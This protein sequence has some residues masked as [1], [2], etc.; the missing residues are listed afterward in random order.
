MDFKT[1][2]EKVSL[3]YEKKLPFVIFSIANNET[4]RCYCQQNDNLYIHESLNKNGFVLAPFDSRLESYLIPQSESEE[5]ETYLNSLEIEKEQVDV[6]ELESERIAYE[7][8]IGKTIDTIQKRDAEKIVVSR[9][10]DFPLSGFS[11]RSLIERLFSAY[12]SAFRY[13]WYHPKT[14]IWC[15]ATPETLVEINQNQFKT[16]ALAGTQPFASAEITWRKKELEEQ[17][18][19]TE[20]ILENLKGIVKNIQVSETRSHR[21]GSLLHLRTDISGEL[22]E[23]KGALAEIARAL[24]PT[25]AICGTPQKFAQEFIIENENYP[26]EFYTGYLGPIDDDGAS[27]TLM[28]NLRCMKIKDGT[29]TIFVGG[30]ITVDSI[31]KEEWKETQNK[32]QTMLQVLRPML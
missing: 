2:I 17:H 9:K 10:K 27:A 32:M 19:V 25:P 14:G 31:P 3:H 7:E 12:P 29:A 21:A 20:A 18:F 1:L 6:S 30:G 22:G 26:R 24:H 13:V 23:E 11:I 16:M 28:V 8:F 5:S 4:V 15:G